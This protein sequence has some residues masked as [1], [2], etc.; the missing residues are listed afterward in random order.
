MFSFKHSLG[1]FESG[2]SKGYESSV[3]L[4]LEYLCVG[5]LNRKKKKSRENQIEEGLKYRS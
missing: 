3:K 1:E 2:C 5:H 4:N